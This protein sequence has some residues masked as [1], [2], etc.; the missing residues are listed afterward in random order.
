[1]S[2]PITEVVGV[3]GETVYT[4][5][6]SY[7]PVVLPSLV[8][9]ERERAENPAIIVEVIGVAERGMPWHARVRATSSRTSLCGPACGSSARRTRTFPSIG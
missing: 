1:M 5:D 4:F 3:P 9:Y 8:V 6:L 7:G 2:A